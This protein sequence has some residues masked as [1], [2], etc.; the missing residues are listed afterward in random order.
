MADLFKNEPE[1]VA[2]QSTEEEQVKP[3][4]HSNQI[5][6]EQCNND[7]KFESTENDFK[8]Q[9]LHTEDMEFK[10]NIIY[11]T[12]KDEEI[13]E[14]GVHS[15]VVV[16]D[17]M[18][19]DV[20]G[21]RRE[22][23]F[24]CTMCLRQ[25]SQKQNLDR[26]FLTLHKGIKRFQCRICRKRFTAKA[27][28]TYHIR[29]H[30][31]ETPFNCK[32]C[33]R[34]F[35]N[36]HV[37]K[38]HMRLHTGENLKC[39]YCS[40][41]SIN[42]YALYRHLRTH[43]GALNDHFR[44]HSE[45][46]PFKYKICLQQFKGKPSLNTQMKLHTD[47]N[48]KCEYCSKQFTEKNQFQRHLLTHK[49]KK[50]YQCDFCFRKFKVMSTLTIHLR[51]HIGDKPF[52][53]DICYEKFWENDQCLKHKR[54]HIKKLHTEEKILKCEKCFKECRSSLLLEKHLRSHSRNEPY[55]CNVCSIKFVCI[56][57]FKKHIDKHSEYKLFEYDECGNKL[58]DNNDNNRWV[59]LRSTH[60]E[61]SL[62]KVCMDPQKL[63]LQMKL[64]PNKF[65]C[66]ICSQV[67]TE[68][69]QLMQHKCVYTKE[70]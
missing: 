39:Q 54:K 22:K 13:N 16:K 56:N 31:G 61:G 35:R 34:Q 5:Q 1:N 24:Q 9:I 3:K 36:I 50:P 43:K 17:S 67:F 21:D 11:D 2:F 14:K 62:E 26:H 37:L 51:T 42:N 47:E 28:L 12:P 30:S 38:T 69:D 19:S 41:Q 44:T 40:K 27:S 63:N 6:T 32:V 4:Y 7:L 59:L 60:T 46:T 58:S 23:P 20:S 68:N 55:M 70:T 29:V 18:V 10:P 48:L 45:E 57:D 53:C 25:F 15:L 66:D 52:E 65:K 8:Y 64:H 49:G 33:L